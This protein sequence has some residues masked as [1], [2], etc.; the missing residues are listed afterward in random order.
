MNVQ[1]FRKKPVEIKAVQLTAE[2][3]QEV[4]AW[5]RSYDPSASL[6]SPRGTEWLL[7]SGPRFVDFGDWIAEWDANPDHLTVWHDEDFVATFEAVR[8]GGEPA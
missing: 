2:N 4:L 5:A 7:L 6:D 3:K 1:T 8:P